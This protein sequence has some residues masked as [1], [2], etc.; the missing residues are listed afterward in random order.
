[1]VSY[2]CLLKKKILWFDLMVVHVDGCPVDG[3]PLTQNRIESQSGNC[4]FWLRRGVLCDKIALPPCIF[5]LGC[6]NLKLVLQGRASSPS[7]A[8]A[9]RKTV[10]LSHQRL[11][12]S[13]PSL[14]STSPNFSTTALTCGL[15]L[16]CTTTP[17][18]CLWLFAG[19]R[20]TWTKGKVEIQTPNLSQNL[21]LCQL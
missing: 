3:C 4:W 1:M 11:V 17:Y 5:A 6:V 9:Q 10:L 2:G 16:P 15:G 7:C 20:I 18:F 14:T 13:F 21:L 8:S 12:T 19:S